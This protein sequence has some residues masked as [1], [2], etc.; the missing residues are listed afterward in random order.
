MTLPVT[1]LWAP[2]IL[3]NAWPMLSKIYF[4]DVGQIL[5]LVP[6]NAYFCLG[7]SNQISWVECL[8]QH[9]RT[10]QLG[11][12]NS[13]LQDVLV[14]PL[15][16]TKWQ[17]LLKH[18]E[19]GNAYMLRAS[20]CVMARVLSY[21]II[22]LCDAGCRPWATTPHC[23]ASTFT[24]LLPVCAECPRGAPWGL[25]WVSVLSVCAECP[26]GAPWG[27]YWVSVLIVQEVRLEVC[28]E[29]LYW[30]SVL[31]VQEV[32]LASIE[33]VHAGFPMDDQRGVQFHPAH[34]CCP[35]IC[36]L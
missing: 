8:Y 36:S 31:S 3:F 14:M 11:C 32:R 17:H 19:A 35:K 22:C 30:V 34:S 25:H 1:L 24:H 33:P 29:C 20:I 27:L 23:W 28:T 2:L 13:V 12:D 21:G 6:G 7:A 9:A 18:A 26:R 10:R 5:Y 16:C 4:F 15:S